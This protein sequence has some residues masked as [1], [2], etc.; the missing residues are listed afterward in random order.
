MD[1]GGSLLGLLEVFRINET[2]NV[3][4]GTNTP[5]GALDVVGDISASGNITGSTIEAQTFV[6]QF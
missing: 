2:G 1:S 5:A 6:I 4:I 3:G